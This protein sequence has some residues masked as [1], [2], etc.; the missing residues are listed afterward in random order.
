MLFYSYHFFFACNT[1]HDNEWQ[2]ELVHKVFTAN[3]KST[4][5]DVDVS[6]LSSREGGFYLYMN[7]I[8]K[9]WDLSEG[10]D[11]LSKDKVL[12]FIKKL[13]YT[14][15]NN[16]YAYLICRKFDLEFFSRESLFVPRKV[17]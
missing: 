16:L 11:Y 6:L 3:Q 5:L 7:L 4:Y 13:P 1:N 2:Q 9:L 14:E 8:A 15:K 17:N 10:K 12:G